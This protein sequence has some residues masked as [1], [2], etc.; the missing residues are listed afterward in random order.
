MSDMVIDL[1]DILLFPEIKLRNKLHRHRIVLGHLLL[2]ILHMR[3][4]QLAHT[5]RE[6]LRS[7]PLLKINPGQ[8]QL[9][10]HTMIHT[11]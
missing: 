8:N 3:H 6:H 9:N 7:H 11:D 4:I 5:T 1:G 2:T 10:P